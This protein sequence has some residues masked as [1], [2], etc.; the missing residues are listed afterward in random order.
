M[1][2]TGSTTA[3]METETDRRQLLVTGLVGAVAASTLVSCNRK[4]HEDE[5]GEEVGAVEDLMRE[6][7]VIRRV[8]VIYSET[9]RKLAS[10]ATAID[11]AALADAARLFR[12]FGEDYHEHSLEEQHIFP[13][14]RAAHSP[15]AGLVDTLLLQHQRG[16]AITDYVLA[17]A[18]KGTI[19]SGDARPLADAM[20]ALVRMYEPHAAREDTI[21]FPAWKEAL[22]PK[23][24]E[25]AGDLFEDI[26]RR[27]FGHDGFEDAVRRVADIEQRLGLGDL[28]AFTAPLPPSSAPNA[29]ASSGNK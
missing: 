3:Q 20:N 28:A 5:A 23:R 29:G 11:A 12:S 17:T 22:G 1:P 18:A 10:G 13:Q 4:R 8:L 25:Q 16:R 19:G 6:H 2:A 14:L 9:S 21:V 26:E 24:V 7:G 27:T 15:A